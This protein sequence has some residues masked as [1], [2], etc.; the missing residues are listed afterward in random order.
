MNLALWTRLSR[1]LCLGIELAPTATAGHDEA[2]APHGRLD[3][4][5]DHRDPTPCGPLDPTVGVGG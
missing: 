4:S 5:T 1:R 3:W 2:T